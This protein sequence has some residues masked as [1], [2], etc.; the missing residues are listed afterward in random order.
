MHNTHPVVSVIIPTYNRSHL[1]QRAVKSVLAQTYDDFELIVVNDA[2]TDKTKEVIRN[3]EDKRIIYICNEQNRGASAARNM[4]IISA[5][6]KYIALLDDDDE[7]LP[8]KLEKQIKRFQQVSDKVGLIYSGAKVRKGSANTTLKTYFPK[9]RGNVRDKLLIG[10]TICGLHTVLIK[11]ECF[12]EVGLFDELLTSCQDWDM[13]KRIAEHFEF[14]FVENVLSITYFHENQISSDY[15]ALIP[16]RTRM[17]QK[18]WDDFQKHP[19]ILTIHLKRLGK[20]HC[21]NGTWKEAI[22]WFKEALKVNF[23][24]IVKIVAWCVIELPIAK[25]FSRAKNFRKYKF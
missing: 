6:G 25:Y 2:S 23:L 13:W 16:G 11:K 12:E 21:I 3:F 1:V 4:G 15:S 10:T 19:G 18:H 7:W 22:Y 14:D 24:E 20:L 17:V 8:E 5:R 9:C